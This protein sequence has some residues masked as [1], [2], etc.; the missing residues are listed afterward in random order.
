M[1]QVRRFSRPY[2]DAQGDWV[3][4]PTA[5]ETREW[6]WTTFAWLD[7][8]EADRAFASRIVLSAP[9]IGTDAVPYCVFANTHALHLLVQHGDKFTPAARDRLEE[10]G[11]RTIMDNPGG[12]RADLQFHG[13][14]DNMP[15]KATLGLILGGEYFGDARAV[16]HG[17]WNL[18]QL[19][20]I[21]ARRGVIAEHCS[22]TYTPLT[23]TNLT[24]IA[25][26]SGNAEAR[27]L[28]AAC[29][30]H[31]WAELMAHYH[32]PTR[33]IAGPYSRAYATDSA[34]HLSNLQFLLWQTF[35]PDFVPDPT[36]GIF[37]KK[38]RLVVHHG[39]DHFFVAANNA[40]FASCEQQPPAHLI[41]WL[42][43][44]SFPF[45]FS[46]TAERGEGGFLT[47]EKSYGDFAA[48]RI[49]VRSY[50]TGTFAI[51]TS[52]GDWINQA[53]RWH[54]VY[55][56]T[57]QPQ[58]R[59]LAD[60]RHLTLR[61]L[62]N[63]YLPGMKAVSPRGD[64]EGEVDYV[65]EKG[66]YHT[67]HKDNITLV[68]ARPLVS[69]AGQP[70]HRMGLA[71]ILPEHLNTVDDVR[72]EEGHLWIEDG[73]FMLA[74]RPLGIRSWGGSTPE[75]S[76]IQSGAYRL[77]F[78]PNYQGEPRTF[79]RE[80]LLATT[81]GFVAVAVSRDETD[82]E[83][84]REMLRAAHL[85]DTIWINQRTLRWEG[86]G[87]VLEMSYGLLS[88]GLRFA[89]IDGVEPAAVPWLAD[90]LDHAQLPLTGTASQPNP[91]PY[92]YGENGDGWGVFPSAHLASHAAEG[93]RGLD[94]VSF[95]ESV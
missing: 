35:G 93:R 52:N 77:L 44:R 56:R 90:G 95:L 16:E 15:A 67:L 89:T 9:Q 72:F 4:T 53:E 24:E 25:K 66:S 26:F 40:F 48:S 27:Q 47:E 54:V 19:R 60:I 3:A 70:I 34:G 39:G 86:F 92:P 57:S 74:V 18:H 78:F 5:P 79:T 80:E 36:P 64:D 29:C 14:N 49:A 85:R 71:I 7:G 8:D 50:Q 23:L 65:P 73:P 83:T 59:T 20:L 84:F 55:R 43:Q 75:F 81:N 69:L 68:A 51:G 21:L 30:E 41:A 13:Y 10:W 82:M 2:F 12:A 58:A 38:T 62:V 28:A 22:P 37:S 45:A 42:K 31:I 76:V 1:A 33:A 11:R 61:Y 94:A 88:D 87:H 91:C 46:A 6:L 32:A 63:D 17:L